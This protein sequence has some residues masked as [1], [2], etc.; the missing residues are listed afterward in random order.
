[1]DRATRPDESLLDT[2]CKFRRVYEITLGQEDSWY[3]R[4]ENAPSFEGA[5]AI[6]GQVLSALRRKSNYANYDT[7][8]EHYFEHD[9][10]SDRPVEACPSCTFRERYACL[11]LHYGQ[12][13]IPA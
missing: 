6:K 2:L 10:D 8:I 5:D 11:L 13:T 1:M 4:L 12:A 7:H 9:S 3:T